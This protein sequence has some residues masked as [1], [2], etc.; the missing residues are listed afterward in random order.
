MNGLVGRRPSLLE[1]FE[2]NPHI[3]KRGIGLGVKRAG[4]PTSAERVAKMAKMADETSSHR[5]FRDRAKH[6]YEERRAEGRLGRSSFH[7]I[8]TTA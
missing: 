1:S 2:L 8:V 5:D 7:H 6:E 3:G 4:S